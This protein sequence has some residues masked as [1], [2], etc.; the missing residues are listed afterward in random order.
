MSSRPRTN[1]TNPATAR[2]GPAQV[3]D[4]AEG[5]VLGCRDEDDGAPHP[6]EH[7]VW[8]R[9]WCGNT[10]FMEKSSE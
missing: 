9:N 1:K 7:T 8:R 2:D 10:S 6:K 4:T 5:M 3:L